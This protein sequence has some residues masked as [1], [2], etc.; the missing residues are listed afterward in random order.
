VQATPAYTPPMSTLG[1]MSLA[2]VRPQ[3]A[4]RL[5]WRVTGLMLFVPVALLG[6]VGCGAEESVSPTPEAPGFDVAAVQASFRA[7]CESPIIVDD[8]FCEQVT[9]GGMTAEGDILN[10]PTGLNALA[11]DRAQA[12]CDQI[13]IAHFDGDG[14]DLGFNYF[15]ILDQ[16]GGN[17]AACV[18][19]R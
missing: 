8:L 7:E 6:L 17:A 5:G 2:W 13:A 15:G 1:A 11:D 4:L 10:V 19:S 14:N 16:D 9:I 3:A 18:V 12:I